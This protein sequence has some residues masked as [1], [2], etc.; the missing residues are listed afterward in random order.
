MAHSSGAELCSLASNSFLEFIGRYR[1]QYTEQFGSM[2]YH[3]LGASHVG[4]LDLAA[5]AV[6]LASFLLQTRSL[7][8]GLVRIRIPACSSSPAVFMIESIVSSRSAVACR[9]K[10]KTMLLRGSGSQWSK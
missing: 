1:A 3:G 4:S 10:N 9:M 6:Q 2:G 5:S 8:V 7:G